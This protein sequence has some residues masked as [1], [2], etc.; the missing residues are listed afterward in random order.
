MIFHF[1]PPGIPRMPPGVLCAGFCAERLEGG[2]RTICDMPG[3]QKA[4]GTRDLAPTAFYFKRFRNFPCEG[5]LL[6]LPFFIYPCSS[7]AK[8]TDSPTPSRPL[9][10]ISSS[11]TSP[12]SEA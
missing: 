3:V 1:Q 5:A 7:A 8:D 2:S 4:V 11:T 12:V 6:W 9:P 10:S